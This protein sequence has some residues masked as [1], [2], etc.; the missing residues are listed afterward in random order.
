MK[1]YSMRGA[2]GL[3]V[4]ILSGGAALAQQ[5]GMPG[6]YSGPNVLS[7]WSRLPGGTNAAPTSLRVALQTSY[8]Y[9]GGLSG[10][11]NNAPDRA[12][13][14]DSNNI[15]AGGSLALTRSDRRSALTLG[16]QANY[17]YPITGSVSTYRGLNQDLNLNY[18]RT[19][20]RR[21]GFYTG[22]SAGSQS[23]ILGLQRPTSQRNFFDQSYS[24]TNEALDARMRFLNS[25][26][27]VYFRKTSRLVFSV[28]GGVFTVSRTSDALV[29]SR[30]ERAQGEISYQT[31]K[32]QSIG[33]IYSFNHFY[34][35]RGFGETFTHSA[36][37]SLSR[38]FA[39]VWVLQLA[40]GPYRAESER[41]RTI[42][43]DPYIAA[44][45]GQRST[46]EVFQGRQVGLSG[47][48]SAS[49]TF[50]RST[51]LTAYRRT[52][53]PGNGVTLT[54]VNDL[55]QINYNF[56]ATRK[57]STGF[58]FFG[59]R[60]SP[61]LSGLDRNSN[62]RSY[63]GF[64]NTGYKLGGRFYAIANVGLQSIAYD[65]L[66]VSV[67]RRAASVGLAFSPGDLPLFR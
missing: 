53:D 5:S 66:N 32:S 30:G 43:V 58:S 33:L 46:I 8:G 4:L 56:T 14:S 28:D 36:M 7:R 16:Y 9:L 12:S 44:L 52:V 21:L 54:A 15:L 2:S 45:T 61:L 19:L 25:G 51:F 48:I 37:L 64:F 34:F 31:S 65:Q 35:Q 38:R 18:E 17:T 50:R 29:S 59:S 3:T 67:I 1:I 26:A 57:W 39:K 42:A 22:H 20:T 62:F 11:V 6:Q 60:M 63:G 41:L 13:R 27:G 49:A 23:S 47:S 40:A 24:I 55:G 10:P